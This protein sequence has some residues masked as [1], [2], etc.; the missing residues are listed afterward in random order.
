MLR[1]PTPAG[2]DLPI[3]PILA[4]IVGDR[5]STSRIS[6]GVWRMS[7]WNPEFEFREKLKGAMLSPSDVIMLARME[8]N[9]RINGKPV[10]SYHQERRPKNVTAMQLYRLHKR[11]L[12]KVNLHD[13]SEP[14]RFLNEYGVVDSPE[15]LLGFYDFEGDPRQLFISMVEIR[16]ED[17]ESQG[18]WRYHKWGPYYGTQKPEHEYLYDDK[19]IDAV[20]TYHVYEVLP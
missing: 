5:G 1:D 10:D 17:E 14:S 4:I 3:H 7:H 16:R 20:W 19:H 11:P 8:R 18:G 15:Q 13:W 9:A 12:R 2:F 6:K